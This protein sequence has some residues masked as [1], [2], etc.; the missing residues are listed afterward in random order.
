MKRSAAVLLAAIVLVV[1]GVSTASARRVADKCW[2]IPMSQETESRKAGPRPGGGFY[3]EYR[4]VTRTFSIC[5]KTAY[6]PWH[7]PVR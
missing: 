5:T 2:T 6:G 3:V 1:G 4:T 7:P